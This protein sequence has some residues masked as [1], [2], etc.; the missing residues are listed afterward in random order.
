MLE[1]ADGRL[2]AGGVGVEGDADAALARIDCAGEGGHLI[3]GQRGAAGGDADEVAVS[4]DADRDG[5]ERAFDQD[6]L[7]ALGQGATGF[8]EAGEDVAFREERGRRG[9][10]IFRAAAV[11]RVGMSAADETNDDAVLSAQRDHEP[12]VEVVAE[13]AVLAV[14]DQAGAQQCGVAVTEAA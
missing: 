9:I 1:R 8:G 6:G 2:A 4:G 11:G 3:G 7:G 13:L 12:V 14:D 5:V 10:E